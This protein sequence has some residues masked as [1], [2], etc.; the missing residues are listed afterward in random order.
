MQSDYRIKTVLTGCF[1]R[2]AKSAVYRTQ[3][4]HKSDPV[5]LA[6][7]QTEKKLQKD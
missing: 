5:P 1:H 7:I 2:H 4:A 6:R 3:W